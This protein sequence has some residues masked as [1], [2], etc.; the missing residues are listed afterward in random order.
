MQQENLLQDLNKEL[1][2]IKEQLK[3]I[4]ISLEEKDQEHK[5]DRENKVSSAEKR[6]ENAQKEKC[7]ITLDHKQA[8]R[9]ACEWSEKRT[10]E[11]DEKKRKLELNSI[12][13]YGYTSNSYNI[14]HLGNSSEC[15]E[16][17]VTM[18]HVMGDILIKLQRISTA[19]K[20][21]DDDK[22][23][24]QWPEQ[25]YDHRKRKNEV[26]L[27]YGGDAEAMIRTV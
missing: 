15:F 20:D 18:S 4:T 26:P 17:P 10:K 21:E 8:R 11:K 7:S 2:E 13:K 16:A 25:L 14:D 9:M 3:A 22:V 12:V 23:L 19:T 24:T 27:F 5:N 1:K 6:F